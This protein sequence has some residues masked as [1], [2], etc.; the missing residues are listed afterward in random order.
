MLTRT[1]IAFWFPGQARFCSWSCWPLGWVLPRGLTGGG[2]AHRRAFGH[3]PAAR[4]AAPHRRPRGGLHGS[5]ESGAPGAGSPVLEAPA[6][7]A[8]VAAPTEN[9]SADVGGDIHDTGPSLHAEERSGEY[10]HEIS[11]VTASLRSLRRRHP[12]SWRKCFR[13]AFIEWH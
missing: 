2:F 4:S 1:G 12:I 7:S 6:R 9:V 11:R 5:G 8:G 10:V 13:S 3:R